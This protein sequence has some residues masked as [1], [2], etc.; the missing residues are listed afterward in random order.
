M[1][2]LFIWACEK[3]K[4][5]N[6]DCLFI[7]IFVLCIII[8]KGDILRNMSVRSR[9]GVQHPAESSRETEPWTFSQTPQYFFIRICYLMKT[10]F[11]IIRVQFYSNPEYFL[12]CWWSIPRPNKEIPPPKKGRMLRL[13]T[14]LTRCPIPMISFPSFFILLTNSMGNMPPSNALLNCLAAASRAPPNRSP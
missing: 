2:G 4:V 8:K 1:S 3:D 12:W 13:L 7:F 11:T 10:R 6:N 9:L 5:E 14:D